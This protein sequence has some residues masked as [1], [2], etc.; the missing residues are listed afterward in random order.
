MAVELP[1][2]S[3]DLKPGMVLTENMVPSLHV[4]FTVPIQLLA[5]FWSP[6]R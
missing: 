3:W 4:M 1:S 6:G 5:M 2:G